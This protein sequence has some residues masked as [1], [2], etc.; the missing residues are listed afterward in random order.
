MCNDGKTRYKIQQRVTQNR[1]QQTNALMMV[2]MYELDM[3]FLVLERPHVAKRNSYM[4][5]HL[6]TINTG[7]KT[8]QAAI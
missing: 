2:D 1:A 4:A 6:Q 7:F 8:K 3:V 5:R